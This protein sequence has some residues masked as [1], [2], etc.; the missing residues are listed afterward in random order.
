VGRLSVTTANAF[1]TVTSTS[2]KGRV[3]ALGF[4]Y[5]HY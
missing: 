1:S 3:L 5:L 2:A 4:C